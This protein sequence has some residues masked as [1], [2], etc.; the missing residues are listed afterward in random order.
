MTV[1]RDCD[2]DDDCDSESY[3]R[4]SR[5]NRECLITLLKI[6]GEL[7]RTGLLLPI[8][9]IPGIVIES[10]RLLR[11]E[12]CSDRQLRPRPTNPTT[13]LAW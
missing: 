6:T 5:V 8:P 13:V 10:F 1:I 3:S 7:A 4:D 12:L 2:C 11:R 9:E